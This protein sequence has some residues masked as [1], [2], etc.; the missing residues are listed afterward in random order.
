MK[1]LIYVLLVTLLF[2]PT[3]L[4][5]SGKDINVY[6]FHGEECP[7]CKEEKVFLDKYL[8]KNK[9]VHLVDYEVWH[10]DDNL[11]LYTEVMH[12]LDEK[13]SGGPCL[14]VGNNAIIGYIEDYTDEVITNTINYYLANNYVDGVGIYLGVV[15]GNFDCSG[16]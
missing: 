14:I 5:A 16:S 8:K 13:A 7:H 4:F 15:K 2:I 12:L 11:A 3:V 6:W 9:N 10:D 1:K